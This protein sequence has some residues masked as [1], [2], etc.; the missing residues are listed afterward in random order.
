[1]SLHNYPPRSERP[2]GYRI[3]TENVRTRNQ[4]EIHVQGISKIL[5]LTHTLPL[6]WVL[7]LG[8]WGRRGDWVLGLGVSQRAG[9]WVL[10]LGAARGRMFGS[11]TTKKQKIFDTE[12]GKIAHFLSVFAAKKYHANLYFCALCSLVRIGV[13]Q[14][15]WFGVESHRLFG[16]STKFSVTYGARSARRK[17]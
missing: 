4:Q 12:R 1:M 15:C 16:Y 11:E 8:S 2:G 10:G 9:S 17:F 7:G 6:T 3:D 14:R 13:G 5:S